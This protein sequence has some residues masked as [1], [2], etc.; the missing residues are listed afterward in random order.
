MLTLADVQKYTG[1]GD[2]RTVRKYFP[3]GKSNIISAHVVARVM[4]GGAD[5]V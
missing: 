1:L 3:F 5:D 4:A 2:Y